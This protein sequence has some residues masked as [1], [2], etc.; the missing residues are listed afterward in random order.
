MTGS[1]RH[2]QRGSS[3]LRRSALVVALVLT[4]VAAVAAVV[5]VV[6]FDG[7]GSSRSVPVVG[8]SITFFAGTDISAALAGAYHAHTYGEIGARIDEVLPTLQG[9]IR[10]SPFAVVVNLGT[11]D[12]LQAQTH[13]DWRS[14]FDR[15]IAVLGPKR[16]VLLTTISTLLPGP[17][18]VQEVAS[19]IN[20]GIATTVRAHANMHVVDWNAA[21]HGPAGAGLLVPDRI[22]PS[23]AGQLT[24]AGLV[25]RAVDA[26]CRAT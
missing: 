8:D 1:G 17:S 18:A 20:D 16:C 7:R 10:S 5:A 19:A 2:G 12:A 11:N 21:V 15:M 13:P 23:A 9:A 14:G 26:N 6:A 22:H 25:R 24:L 4:A 3:V